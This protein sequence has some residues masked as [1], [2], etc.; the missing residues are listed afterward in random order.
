MSSYA[1]SFLKSHIIEIVL[2]IPKTVYF[3][4]KVLP[5]PKAIRMPFIVSKNVRLEGVNRDTF[6]VNDVNGS[7][8]TASMRIGFGESKNARRESPRGLIS[9]GKNGKIVVGSGLGLSQ[10]C[11]L[12]A[13]EACLTLGDNFRCNYSTTIDCYGEDITFGNNVVCG[14][15]VTVRNGDGHTVLHQGRS[16]SI[17]K[18]IS[19]GDHVWICANATVL[20]GVNIGKDSVVAYG[21]ILTKT[22]ES[23]GIL[24]GGIPARVLRENVNWKE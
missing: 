11:V 8:T 1:V 15:K 3:N 7:L 10:G 19:V 18:K 21:S 6:V 16:G 9:I 17:T 12:I 14:W 4:F 2:S 13:N 24:Y 22:V 5:L 23:E 20:K